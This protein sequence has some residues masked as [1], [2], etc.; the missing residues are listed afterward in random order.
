MVDGTAAAPYSA[1]CRLSGKECAKLA[2]MGPPTTAR[3]AW[4][5]AVASEVRPGEKAA[6]LGNDGAWR[7]PPSS[8]DF[9]LLWR[10]SF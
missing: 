4:A 5:E 2:Q 1:A 7:F 3:P 10:A 6:M 9:M 8:V